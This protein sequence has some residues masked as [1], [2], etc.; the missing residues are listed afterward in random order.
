MDDTPTKPTTLPVKVL[1]GANADVATADLP[2]P[3]GSRRSPLA[4]AKLDK[5]LEAARTYKDQAL[6][7]N[8]RRAYAS[9]W[10]IF[11]AWCQATQVRFLPADS[12]TV[13]LFIGQQAW[14]DPDDKTAKAVSPSTIN[15]R[16]AAIDAVH[17]YLGHPPPSKNKQVRKTLRGIRNQHGTAPK[18]KAAVLP[19]DIKR[20]ADAC[21]DQGNRALRDRALLLFGFASAMRRSELV[22]LDREHLEFLYRVDIERDEMTG[23]EISR[24]KVLIGV[25]VTIPHSKTDQQ[26]KGVTIAVPVSEGSSYCPVGALQD[27]LALEHVGKPAVFIR[28]S[29]G[30]TLLFK[31]RRPKRDNT[32]EYEEDERVPEPQR[33]S[34]Q[35]VA[36][37]LKSYAKNLDLDDKRLGGHS[38]RRGW[39]TSAAQ[40]DGADIFKMAEHSRHKSM[41]VLR[42]YVDD[43]NKLKDHAGKNLLT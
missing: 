3:D 7:A 40:E 17:E 2:T 37:L 10:R 23:E 15:R 33:L 11:E 35:S 21:G 26:K 12:A 28:V 31:E 25:N 39:L 24:T 4:Q 8:T 34:S 5:A 1:S 22:A 29:K 20:L 14:P 6:A 27:W 30:D 18:K 41:D 38:L 19:D 13:D 43:A 9:D 32:D 36:L 16:L 42:G